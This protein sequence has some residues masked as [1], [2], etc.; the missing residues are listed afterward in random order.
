MDQYQRH[1][2]LKKTFSWLMP[3]YYFCKNANTKI[4]NAQ[5]LK[6]SKADVRRIKNIHKGERCFIIGNGPSLRVEDLE[7]L[8]DEITFATNRIFVLFDKTDWRPT[9]YCAADPLTINNS[10]DG[11]KAFSCKKKFIGLLGRNHYE[12]IEDATF[13]YLEQGDNYPDLPGFSDDICA[14][15]YCSVTVTYMCFQVAVYMGFN[16]IYLLGV[17]NNWSAYRKADGTVVRQENV[18]DHFDEKYENYAPQ[19]LAP[20]QGEKSMLAYEGALKY[21][22]EHDIKIYNATRGGKLEVFER[23]D[24]DT[25][26]PK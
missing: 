18:A 9:Y 19:P 22:Q 3:L 11:I 23:V 10:L 26:F 1:E 17:D 12:E 2:M 13:L 16:E 25:L 14:K 15:V 5:R 21:A 6:K 8:R 24:F 20:P 7:K 4:V